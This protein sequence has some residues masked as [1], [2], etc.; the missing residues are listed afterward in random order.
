MASLW[1]GTYP[2]RNGV[3]RFDHS[4][5]EE[6]LLPAEVLREAG[7]RTAGVWRNGWVAPN[8][9]FEQGFEFYFNPKP[10][11]ARVQ[12][13]RQHPSPDSLAGTDEDL[14]DSATSFL[15]SYGRERFFLYLHYM[16]LHQYV[17]DDTA[18]DLG[19][20]YSDAY[21]KS[22]HWIDRLIGALVRDLE[23]R[24]LMDRTVIVLA[25]DHGEAFREH[26]FEGHARNLHH[27]VTEVPWLI[28][29][30]FRLSEPIVVEQRAANTD[31]W[32]TVLDLLGLPELPGA[33][34][35]SLV[36]LILRAGG[37]AQ[38]VPPELESRPIFAQ[39]DQRWGAP[40]EKPA[41]L[42]GVADG[43]LRLFLPATRPEQAELFD[44]ATDPAEK[45]DLRE[46]RPEEVARLRAIAEAYLENDESPWGAQAKQ[47]ELDEM[48]LNQL[49]ALGYVI[50]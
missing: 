22:I 41:P 20:A 40:R 38:E 23:D 7:F 4:L 37:V 15:A 26:G 31:V 48:R 17:Y 21:D 36:P 44:R 28:V 45:V 6:A 30:P 8:F 46:Q 39:L 13:Q 25:S 11:R 19:N 9:G 49:R 10:G 3:L 24:G 42:V 16:D 1:T 43:D 47:V 14:A 32:P 27:E 33:D 29:L 50:K 18:P 35:R 2:Q 34:G 12:L 5:P